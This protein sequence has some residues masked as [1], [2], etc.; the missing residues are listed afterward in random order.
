MN[1]GEKE[2]EFQG[3]ARVYRSQ[4]RVNVSASPGGWH[5]GK[6]T[7]PKIPQPKSMKQEKG[8]ETNKT[9]K[10]GKIPRRRKR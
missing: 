2:K 3:Q 4:V 6:K 9:P 5:E 8:R 1:Q 10:G 7:P